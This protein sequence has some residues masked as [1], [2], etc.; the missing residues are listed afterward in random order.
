[1]F[2]KIYKKNITILLSYFLTQNEKKRPKGIAVHL[3]L[4]YFPFSIMQPLPLNDE[5]FLRQMTNPEQ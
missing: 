3:V 2:L 4:F 1:M 5:R